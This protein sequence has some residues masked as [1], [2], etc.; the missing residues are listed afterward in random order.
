[1]HRMPALQPSDQMNRTGR[2]GG[3]TV[4]PWS[5]EVKRRRPPKHVAQDAKR[6]SRTGLRATKRR[7]KT[8]GVPTSPAGEEDAPDRRPSPHSTTQ[9]RALECAGV[10]QSVLEC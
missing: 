6:H 8:P 4:A 2:S 5:Q 3:P 9:S 1:G 10:I 7:I